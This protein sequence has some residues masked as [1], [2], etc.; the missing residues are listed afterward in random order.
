MLYPFHFVESQTPLLLSLAGKS[1]PPNLAGLSL[2]TTQDVSFVSGG[3]YFLSAVADFN[4]DGYDDLLMAWS[5]VQGVSNPHMRIA[6]AVDVTDPTQ[7][8][9]FGP[10]FTPAAPY[11]IRQVT[12][13]DFNGDGQPD[14][15]QAYIDPS[16]QLTLATYRVDPATLTISEGAQLVYLR[17]VDTGYHPVELAAGHFTALDHHQLVVGAQLL[18]G[19][20]VH[21]GFFDFAPNSIQPQR[22]SSVFFDAATSMT[23][24]LKAARFIWSNPFD[25]IAWMSSSG[26]GTRLSVLIVDPQSQ[27]VVRKA[28]IPLVPDVNSDSGVTIDLKKK[29]F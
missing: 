19:D 11:G 22:V 23:L 9:R 27:T 29:I 28:D 16:R 6:T 4:G 12:V 21:M 24:R 10:L 25:Q 15:V 1:V 3:D 20:Q 26:G 8:F 14:I 2:T 18:D 5:H 13:G 7:G 17:T